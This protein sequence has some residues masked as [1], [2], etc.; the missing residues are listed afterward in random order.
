LVAPALSHVSQLHYACGKPSATALI[1]RQPEDFRVTE[2]LSFPLDGE[3]QHVFLFIQK[4]NLNTDQVSAALAKFA[5][6]KQ[7]AVGYAGLKDRQAVT[8]QWFSVDLAG[9]PEP[10]WS[11]LESDDLK[12]LEVTRHGRKLKRGAIAA[13]HFELVLAEFEGER[14]EME[15]RLQKIKLSG[16]P[17]YFGEQRFGRNEANL[18]QAEK[19]MT[20]DK[21][22][23]KRH[24]RSL[25]L[26]AARSFL[27]NMVLSQRVA[28]QTWNSALAG[29]VF[30][31]DGS[32]SIFVPEEIDDDI[33]RRV[34]D[35]DIHPTGPLWGVGELMTQHSVLQLERQ[36]LEAY[37]QWRELLEKAGMKQERRALRLPVNAMESD[38]RDKDVVLKFGLP[39]GSYA[40]VVLRELIS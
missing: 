22:R 11:S 9:K 36:V 31:L 25:Y 10:D 6:V 4:S 8:R 40:T 5:N 38:W 3:G 19:M 18:R 32:H 7:V 14:E 35:G 29:D 30:M 13:N 16:V 12:V 1:R 34:A 37:P 21:L 17:N 15:Q 26:S 28:D 20:N 23:I 27:F 2:Q 24:Q 33:K 39:A